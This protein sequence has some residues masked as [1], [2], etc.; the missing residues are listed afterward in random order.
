MHPLFLVCLYI[1]L[2]TTKG[3]L[4]IERVGDVIVAEARTRRWPRY[5][6]HYIDIYFEVNYFCAHSLPVYTERE[7][8]DDKIRSG[9]KRRCIIA[10]I[11]SLCDG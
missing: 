1:F 8:G 9:W 2:R 3:P 6:A 4:S 7:R 10:R 11:L 5:S